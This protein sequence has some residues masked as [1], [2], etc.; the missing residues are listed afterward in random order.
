M[1]F[2]I[3]LKSI[4]G[5]DEP[6]GEQINGLLKLGAKYS[7]FQQLQKAVHC[8]CHDKKVRLF[9]SDSRK[10]KSAHIRVNPIIIEKA[11]ECLIYYSLTYSC[12]F[13]SKSFKK[14]NKDSASVVRWL[15][16]LFKC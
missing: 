9:R 11:P 6:R 15:H 2:L 1:S 8:Y 5:D 4:T 16:S 13:G 7:S 10:L 12:V 14:R 3:L